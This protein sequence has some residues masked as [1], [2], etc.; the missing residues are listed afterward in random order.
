MAPLF[1][2]AMGCMGFR[3]Q[4]SYFPKGQE[5]QAP[6]RL[7]EEGDVT[8]ALMPIEGAIGRSPPMEEKR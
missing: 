8:S 5:P 7:P 3:E 4:Q 6:F 2:S 1:T